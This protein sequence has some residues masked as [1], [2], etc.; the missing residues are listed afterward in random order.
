MISTLFILSALAAPPTAVAGEPAPAAHRAT[1][2]AAV[3]AGANTAS[4][5]L[6]DAVFGCDFEA[7]SDHDFDSHPDGWTRQ[8]SL[9]LPPYVRAAIVPEGKSIAAALREPASGHDN[10]VLRIE[11]DGG[12]AALGRPAIAVGSHYSLLLSLRIRTDGLVNDGAWATLALCDKQGKTMQSVASTPLSVAG[13]WKQIQIGPVTPDFASVEFAVITLHLGPVG[14]SEDLTGWAEFDDVR[15]VRLPR[16]TLE[17]DRPAGLYPDRSAP[18]II[19]TVSGVRTI[20]PEVRFELIDGQGRICA[21][22][23][24]PLVAGTTAVSEPQ[25]AG[26]SGA[27]RWKPELP[28]FGFYRVQASLHTSGSEAPVLSRTVTLAALRPLARAP[29]SEFGWSLPSGERPYPYGTLTA[30]AN[31]AGLGWAKVPVWYDASQTSEIERVAWLAEQLSIENIEL[32]G[33]FDQPPRELR[34][35]FREAGPLPVASVFI[36]PEL[37]EPVVSPVLTRLS[38]KV[39]W[40]QLGDDNDQSFVGFPQVESKIAEIKSHLQ[41]F[42]QEIRIGVGWQWLA[43]APQPP[44][45][46]VPPW[47]YLSYSGDPELTADELGAYLALPP[48]PPPSGSTGGKRVGLAEREASVSSLSSGKRGNSRQPA[49]KSLAPAVERWLTLA[50]LARGEYSDQT[51]IDDLVLRMIAARMHGASAIFVP[52]PF[53]E[54]RGLMNP[55]GSPGELFVPWRTAAMLLGGRQYA[56]R[57][58]LAGDSECHAFVRDR[59]AVLVVWNDRPAVERLILGAEPQRIDVWGRGSQPKL[60]EDEGQQRHELQVGPSPVFVTGQSAGVARWQAALDFEN[61]RLASIFN[62][63]QMIV[64]RSANHFGQ[65]ISGEVTLHAP[66]SWDID[67]RPSRFKLAEGD[68]L[69]LSLPV[70][71]KAD[72]NSGPQAVRLDFEIA[73][74]RL[75]KFSVYRTLQL[76]LED[77]QIEL[78]TRL[79]EDGVLIVEQQLT[80]T[81]VQPVSF[82]C[83][84]FPPG[85][86]R[87][88]RQVIH[89]ARGTSGLTFALPNGEELIG[90]KLW[91]R[92]EEIGGPRVLNY[93]VVAE[94]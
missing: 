7:A 61:P 44:A 54:S 13:G 28:D 38:L 31:Q 17:T 57:I 62:Q 89:A 30:V 9:A 48:D 42:G 24:T 77:V 10:R 23:A 29:K 12:G 69:R 60:V 90:K 2:P 18:E 35:V 45:K 93:T 51:R 91:L 80:N 59:Q 49:A 22:H 78:T 47:A 27:A 87:E 1:E 43:E 92:A 85:R 81:S 11:L 53:D 36:E 68:E 86:R 26:D 74:D 63:Q 19:C 14:E 52:Q 64:M 58:Q 82:Q 39:R 37:W 70:T 83:L 25:T 84:L 56:G 33:V 3:S 76:G 79:R 15:L 55:D 67:A 32:V 5:T 8:F 40:W 21:T 75:Y 34:Q 4:T 94:R 71:L 50:P 41:Q 46:G 20:A 65:A 16:M 66:P 6:G 88:M 72:A 73:A